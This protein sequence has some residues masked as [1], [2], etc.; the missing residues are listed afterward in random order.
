MV[1]KEP[2]EGKPAGARQAALA[3][4]RDPGQVN[5]ANRDINTTLAN[6]NLDLSSLVS[7]ESTKPQLSLA[8]I[9]L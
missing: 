2:S 9:I 8:N 5:G 1:R 7:R 4:S 6:L 3:Q